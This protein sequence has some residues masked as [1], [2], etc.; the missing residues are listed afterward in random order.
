MVLAMEAEGMRKFCA[1]NVRTKMAVMK[2]QQ[3]EPMPSRGDSCGDFD[4]TGFVVDRVLR[5]L[6]T[7]ASL[8][9][10]I[11]TAIRLCSSDSVVRGRA[12]PSEGAESRKHIAGAKARI[13]S[14]DVDAGTKVPAYQIPAFFSTLFSLLN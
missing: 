7:A 10:M 12:G 9:V 3:R 5:L 8:S 2:V 6:G 14:A 13:D 11:R 4:C 1:T